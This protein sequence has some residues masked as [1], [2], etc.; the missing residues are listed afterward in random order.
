MNETPTA[1]YR[2]KTNYTEDKARGY[3]N[4]DARRNVPELKLVERAFQLIPRPA[5]IGRAHV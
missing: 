3:A 4:R 5:K 2:A 1:T